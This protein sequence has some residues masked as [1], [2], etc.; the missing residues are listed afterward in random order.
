M[1]AYL[2]VMTSEY[3][4]SSHAGLFE[5]LPRFAELAG[6]LV[7]LLGLEKAGGRGPRAEPASD[8][9]IRDYVRRRVLSVTLRDP[10]TEERGF[11]GYR[12][13]VEFLAA[14]VLLNDG[15]PLDKI[16]EHHVRASTEALLELIPG[17][18]QDNPALA[19]AR[20]FRSSAS[21]SI[22]EQP[23]AMVSV[24]P[25]SSPSLIEQMMSE[26]ALTTPA[27]TMFS[28]AATG[29]A[30]RRAELPMLMRAVT[31]D[32][33]MPTVQRRIS[34]DFS[35]RL[36]LSIDAE[37]AETLLPDQADAIGRAIAAA[38]L[39]YPNFVRGKDP[40]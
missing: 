13:L 29:S 24:S 17:Q 15:W 8:R 19:L 6:E 10:L 14:R 9:L 21:E 30:R 4:I 33:E 3:D 12:H 37:W 23:V 34:L 7:V 5:R 2:N 35:D 36:S 26:T 27:Q 16:A 25:D 22:W 31:G 32:S 28:P 18:P 39:D 40:K 11:Y 1:I 20:S 38:L